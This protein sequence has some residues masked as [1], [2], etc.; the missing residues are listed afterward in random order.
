MKQFSYF[1]MGLLPLTFV[2]SLFFMFSCDKN[3][4]SEDSKEVA[5]ERNDE[6]FED[7]ELEKDAQFL[8][9]AAEINMEE[10]QLG[11][12]AQ[13]KGTTA[14]VKELAKTMED[15]HRKLQGELST[16][17]ESKGIAIPSSPT[18]DAR[19]A[20]TDLSK[21]DGDDFDKAYANRMVSSHNDAVSTFEEAS[22]D[23]NDED[24]KQWAAATL[25]VLRQHLD[26]S[27]ECQKDFAHMYIEENN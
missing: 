7:D 20:F 8:V 25:P 4:Q 1:K 14:D 2:T 17:A 6:N 24:I 11:K 9:N 10:I 5:E 22:E 18:E 27:I 23:S 26:Q 12:L 21:K 15:S 13:Q 16:L 19:D 3:Q